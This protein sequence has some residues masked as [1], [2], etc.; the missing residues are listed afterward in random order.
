MFGVRNGKE[1]TAASSDSRNANQLRMIDPSSRGSLIVV[2]VASGEQDRAVFQA[3]LGHEM[4]SG[5]DL[6][7][8]KHKFAGYRVLDFDR[9]AAAGDQESSLAHLRRVVG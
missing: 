9:F 3:G 1:K 7:G 5:V 4:A 6:T 2:G 8:C